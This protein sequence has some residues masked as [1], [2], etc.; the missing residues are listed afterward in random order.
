MPSTAVRWRGCAFVSETDGGWVSPPSPKHHPCPVPTMTYADAERPW[1]CGE[2][3]ATW[4]LYRHF[5]TNIEQSLAA[6]RIL[7]EVEAL[8]LHPVAEQ[9]ELRDRY[10]PTDLTA[11][12]AAPAPLPD[13]NVTPLSKH[14]STCAHRLGTGMCS[15]EQRKYV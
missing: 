6:A 10:A 15:C 9:I 14:S 8:N 5:E 2:C 4:T 7:T 13:S 12:N 3:G 11:P 1:K